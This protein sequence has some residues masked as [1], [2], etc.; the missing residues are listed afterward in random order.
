MRWLAI[1]SLLV[2]AC[3]GT[4]HPPTQRADAGAS[5]AST[6][7][8]PL[9]TDRALGADA[10]FADLVAAAIHE[11]DRRASDSDAGCLLRATS[12]GF[13]LAADLSVAVRGLP[14]A[15]TDLSARVA[16]SGGRA[17][18]LTRFGSYGGTSAF[19]AV[20]L[21]TLA[22][23]ATRQGVVLVLTA[24]GVIVLHTSGGGATDPVDTAHAMASL[25]D[26][27]VFVTA[28]GD[29]PLADLR[30]LL[31]AIPPSLA[32]RVALAAVLPEDA[33]TPDDAAA[34]ADAAPICDGL[35]PL[36]DDAAVGDLDPADLRAALSSSL[37]P[38]AQAC[39]ATSASG[40][41]GLV[42]VAFRIGADG[43]VTDACITEDATG[44]A[45]LRGCLVDALHATAFP[46]PTGGVVDVALPLRLELAADP[47]H[48]QRPLCE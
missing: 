36:A 27:A 10:T 7:P 6:D 9:P 37:V 26:G 15:P 40:L 22:G 44:D 8:P 5:S 21:T 4:Q 14:D 2:V 42:R 43:H 25:G 13:E 19:T 39:V 31:A 16:A 11:D 35:P 47:A 17:R 45:T 34:A 46:H 12:T 23:S 18:V 3:G 29:V 32:G 48:R 28:D 20:A 33:R 1:S 41:G 38:A 30:A 24:H